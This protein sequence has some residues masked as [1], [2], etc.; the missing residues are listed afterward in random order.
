M[1]DHITDQVVLCLIGKGESVQSTTHMCVQIRE[2]VRCE[3][4]SNTQL[5]NS[6]SLHRSPEYPLGHM[7]VSV[8][9][10]HVPPF[11]HGSLGVQTEKKHTN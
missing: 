7:Q 8:I 5:T 11:W 10:L 1:S 9:S 3:T 2:T 6:H 4:Y